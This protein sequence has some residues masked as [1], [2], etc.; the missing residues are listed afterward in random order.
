MA[1]VNILILI[2]GMRP[3]TE[4]SS[5][6]PAYEEF[7]K[8]M[9]RERSRLAEV[10]TK[11]I[12]AQ[13]GHVMPAELTPVDFAWGFRGPS[14][15]EGKLREDEKLTRAEDTVKNLVAY[16]ELKKI[17]DPNNQLLKS[18]GALFSVP[19]FHGIATKFREGMVLTGIGDVV[20]YCSEEGEKRVRA[21]IYEQILRGL[22]EFLDT[23]EVRLHMF[24]HSM[25]TIITH[26]FLFGL[27]ARD[28]TPDFIKDKQGEESAWKRYERWRLKAQK[29]ELKLGSLANAAS[30]I[31]LF[32]M[33]KQSLVERFYLGERLDS[34]MIGIVSSDR[35]Q[36]KIF[37]DAD[38][39]LGFSTRRLYEPS[40][41]IK[42]IEVDCGFHP[43]SAHTGYWSNKTVVRETADLILE[44]AGF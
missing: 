21:V 23:S 34:S 28:H 22:D 37:Y 43:Q 29:G 24:S 33:R 31:P 42:D 12:G 15:A 18:L 7:W 30:Q 36:W 9:V 1:A 2:H 25:G 10:V 38:D 11:R 32:I 27:F 39:F 35:V 26:D 40:A 4:A 8:A 17:S 5:P 44:N 13:W 6:F 14:L 16:D 41:A 20:Y 19:I 3:E